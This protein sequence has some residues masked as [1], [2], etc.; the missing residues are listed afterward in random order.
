MPFLFAPGGNA[1]PKD[2]VLKGSLEFVLPPGRIKAAVL[3]MSSVE[4]L[5]S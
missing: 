1:P 5:F 4:K 3:K 2:P